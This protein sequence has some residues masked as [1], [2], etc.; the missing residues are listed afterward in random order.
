MD[1]NRQIRNLEDI[2]TKETSKEIPDEYLYF[3]Y[4]LD[5]VGYYVKYVQKK[6]QHTSKKNLIYMCG[7]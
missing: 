7:F 3:C 4:K 6:L 2:E 1:D 5:H